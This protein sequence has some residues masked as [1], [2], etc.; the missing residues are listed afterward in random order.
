MVILIPN[1]IIPFLYDIII[2]NKK[3]EGNRRTEPSRMDWQRAIVAVAHYLRRY[4]A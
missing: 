2:E 3:R 1:I 4:D